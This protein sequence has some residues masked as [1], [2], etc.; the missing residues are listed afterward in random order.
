MGGVTRCADGTV[1]HR[2]SGAVPAR[3]VPCGGRRVYAAQRPPVVRSAV[4]ATDG[5]DLG[6]PAKQRAAPTGPALPAISFY[7]RILLAMGRPARASREKSP[8]DNLGAGGFSKNR[9]ISRTVNQ[10][11]SARV[12]PWPVS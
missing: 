7:V 8:S 4:D 11:T 3:C 2:E 12:K 5:D 10:A 9:R 1:D 6:L